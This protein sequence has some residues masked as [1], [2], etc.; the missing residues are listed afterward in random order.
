MLQLAEVEVVRDATVVLRDV[1]WNVPQGASAWITGRSGAGKSSLCRAIVGLDRI[2]AGTISWKTEQWASPSSHRL[3]QRREATL[4]FQE[5][6]LWP[7]ETVEAHVAL[8]LQGWPRANR[9]VRVQSVLDRLGIGSLARRFPGEVSGGQ[10]QRVA[11]ARA[12]ARRPALA[13]LDEPFAHLDVTTV[14]E[15]Q[16]WIAEE[17]QQ[18][19]MTIVYAMHECPAD[20]AC[21]LE[22]KP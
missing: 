12:L 19:G 8:T 4:M 21:V 10:Q 1:S 16:K 9:R 14:A 20:A 13:V 22:L 6:A 7:H 17:Q 2:A 15:V 11:M 18:S 5:L 3:P